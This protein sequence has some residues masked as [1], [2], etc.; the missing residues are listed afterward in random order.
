MILP[1]H[2]HVILVVWTLL[3]LSHGRTLTL[4]ILS[5][6]ALVKLSMW[7]WE[8]SQGT[9]KAPGPHNVS[10]IIRNHGYVI[11]CKYYSFQSLTVP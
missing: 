11:Y 3:P 9:G 10:V 4:E 5:V 6:L 7:I 8:H 2:L 1:L